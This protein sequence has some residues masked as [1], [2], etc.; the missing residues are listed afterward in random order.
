[1]RQFVQRQM[2][3]KVAIIEREYIG[4]VCL[5]VGCIPSK[6]LISAGHKYQE[7]LDSEIFGVKL[8]KSL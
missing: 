5:N 2:G 7:A 1:M 8:K 3:Q 6:A 4:G